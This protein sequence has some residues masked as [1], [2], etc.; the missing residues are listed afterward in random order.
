MKIIGISGSLRKGSYN[1]GLLRCAQSLFP[2]DVNLDIF[3]ISNIPIYNADLDGESKPEAVS[4]L[5][6]TLAVCDGMLF[7]APEYNYSISGVMKNVIDWASRP[8]YQ[9]VLANKPAGILS[10][11][12]GPAGGARAQSQL[13]HV[14]GATLTVVYPS[15]EY[16]LPG[17]GDAFDE[18]GQFQAEVDRKR[19]ERYL[20]G[21]CDWVSKRRQ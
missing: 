5:L 2:E 20:L 19:L 11:S 17:V 6:D 10:A 1:S 12:K 7:A 18:S 4:S 3:N 15:R 14:L 21:F 16:L 13:R 9:S 8:A